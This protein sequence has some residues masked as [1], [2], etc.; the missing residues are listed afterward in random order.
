MADFTKGINE[1]RKGT[2]LRKINEDPTYLSFFF[3]FDDQSR[4][5]SPL[6][7]GAARDYLTKVLRSD[8]GNKYA[9]NL[10]NFKKVLFKINKELPW[11]WQTVSGIDAAL[12]YQKMAEP[13]WGAA[14][15]KLEIECLEENIE[16]TAFGLMDLYKRACFDFTRWVE[17]IPHNLRH[18]TM[19]VY[20]TEVR[21]IQQDTN[22]PNL[23]LRD[24][25]ESGNN[26]SRSA[27]PEGKIKGINPEMSLTAKPYIKLKFEHCEFDIDSI[28][29]MFAD[30]NKNPEAVK[31]KIAIKW[32]SVKQ[33]EQKLGDN[34]IVEEDNNTISDAIPTPEKYNTTP[35]DPKDYVQG[36]L[37]SALSGFTDAA[38]SKFGNLK[39]GIAG[40]NNSEIGNA[41]GD[42][43]GG[44][45]SAALNTAE[46]KLLSKL[47]MGNVHGV[48]LGNIQ[49]AIRSGSINALG[50]LVGDLIGGFGS[51]SSSVGEKVYS[52]TFNNDELGDESVYEPGVDSSAD[53]NLN[54][55]VHE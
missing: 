23:G 48:N 52:S 17:V 43:T 25:P 1:F 45:T 12:T 33:V 14:D 27:P 5:E 37:D 46:E 39:D 47:F 22:A 24:N 19:Y 54:D 16:L 34:L 11:F 13:W 2:R 49:N 35:F 42:S 8:E 30:I 55:N 53:G 3:M 28:A 50:S 31:P 6:L 40:G 18:F 32:N 51:G 36:K 41:F 44:L 15:N 38:K 21:T 20:I 26:S 10:D 9:Q 29:S 7:S 4:M